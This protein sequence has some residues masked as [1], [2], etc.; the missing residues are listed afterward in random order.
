[1][2]VIGGGVGGLAAAARLAA[3]GHAVTLCEQSE[4]LGGKLSEHTRDGFRWD[5]GPSLLTLPQVLEELFA[6]TGEPLDRHL[7]LRRLGASARYRFADSAVVDAATD[8][9]D[10]CARLDAGLAPGSGDD[11]RRLLERAA[12]MWRIVES[13]FLRSPLRG[14]RTLLRLAR[15]A[16]DVATVAPHRTLRG[17]GRQYLRDPRLRMVLDR[18]AT[19]TGSDPRRAPATLAVI[20]YLEQTFG[21]WYVDGGLYRIVEALAERAADLGVILR[22]GADVQAITLEQGRVAGIRLAD[23]E[24]LRCDIVVANA[25]ADHV[26]GDLVPHRVA[27]GPLRRLRRATRSLSGFVLLLG[28]RGETPGLAHHTVLFPHDYDAEFDAIFGS[29]PAPVADPAVHLSVPHDPSVAPPDH[30]AWFVLVNA[31]RHGDVDWA[32]AATTSD[33]ADRVL[34]VLAERGCEVRDR[35]VSRTVI[36]PHDLAQRTRAAGGAIY[37]T[38]SNG[39]SS[40][41]LRPGNVSPVPG[42]FLVGGSS[43]PGGGLPLVLLSAKIVS[44]AVGRAN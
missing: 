43:H 1:M 20:A 13:P 41:F 15:S 6:A 12:A 5:T 35:I 10:F 7:A 36:T 44:D 28:V 2:V 25:D 19:Y 37:G 31:P 3:V 34:S 24:Y 38:S 27:S 40:A 23:G 30:Q 29:R 8:V 11:W 18:Y 26:Y 39:P 16:G 17:L 42:L 33:Y 4:R 22:T 21:A 32:S 14:V 9:D